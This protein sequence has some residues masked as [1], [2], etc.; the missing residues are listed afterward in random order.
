MINADEVLADARRALS[1]AG[2]TSELFSYGDG[3]PREVTPE[4]I[5]ALVGAWCA[6]DEALG[7]PG[8]VDL[9]VWGSFWCRKHDGGIT[10]VDNSSGACLVE[11]FATRLEALDWLHDDSLPGEGQARPIAS[12]SQ[13]ELVE[14]W[15]DFGDAPVDDQDKLVK[16]WR[17]YPEGTDR[18]EIWHD[19]DEAS[20][21][22]VYA[23]A[24]P[25]G[26]SENQGLAEQAHDAQAVSPR[27]GQPQPERSILRNLPEI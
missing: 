3:G 21:R 10:A 5:G 4:M 8:R 19:F 23:L 22:G 26:A 24:F 6:A 16:S 20:E 9:G 11:G 15:H 2:W 12:L 13:D 17:N 7:F 25:D 1:A 18:F 27:G 14:A